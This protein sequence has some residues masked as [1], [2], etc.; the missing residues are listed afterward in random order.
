MANFDWEKRKRKSKRGYK[1]GHQ[2]LIQD[3]WVKAMV[4]GSDKCASVV[5]KQTTPVKKQGNTCE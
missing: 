4:R 2:I 3:K 5:G 1:L